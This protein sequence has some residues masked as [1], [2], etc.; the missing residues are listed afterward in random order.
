MNQE[1]KKLR[2]FGLFSLVVC[3][4]GALDSIEVLTQ[5]VP[6]AIFGKAGSA[7][8]CVCV[9]ERERDAWVDLPGPPLT[10]ALDL[11]GSYLTWPGLEKRQAFS[12]NSTPP[13]PGRFSY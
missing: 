10:I 9:R 1:I 7:C 12:F 11:C 8:V 4:G 13:T 5:D 3:I 6:T 2:E